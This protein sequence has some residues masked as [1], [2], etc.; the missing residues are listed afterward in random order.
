V[1]IKIITCLSSVIFLLS[2]NLNANNTELTV[3]ELRIAKA[4]QKMPQVSARFNV[5][6]AEFKAELKKAQSFVKLDKLVSESGLLLW[7]QAIRKYSENNDF[8]DRPLYWGRLQMMAEIKQSDFFAQLSSTQQQQLLWKAELVTRGQSDIAFDKNTTYKV[9]L[10]G[11]DPFFLDR[12]LDQSNPSGV[13]A[14]A[15]DNKVI[16]FDGATL[17]IETVI[18]PVRYAD[19][20]QGMIEE[21][22]TPYMR[23]KKVDMV[24]T[25]SMGREGFDLERFPGLRRSANAP[26]NLN[27]FT[28]ASS[29]KP[30]IPLLDGKR[31]KGPEFNLF[32]LPVEEMKTADGDFAITDNHKVTTTEKTFRPATIDELS[33]KISVQG[34]GGG[35]LSNEISYRSLLLRDQHNPKLPVGHIH[36]PRFKGFKP[37]KIEKIVEQVEQMIKMSMTTF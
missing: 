20:D 10:T 16:T 13:V 31:L 21:L 32:S 36:T 11:F 27:V 3:E 6:L 12:N 18:V 4:K 8:D 19:F 2:S 24:V 7:Q 28:G 5:L 23:D 37:Q 29:E 9:L 34:S 14:T 33:G 1:K 17:E 30:L 22:L 26:D 35:Y 15:F 25:V